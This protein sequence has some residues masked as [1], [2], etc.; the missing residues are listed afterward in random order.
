VNRPD[1]IILVDTVNAAR[2]VIV[3]TEHRI[4]NRFVLSLFILGVIVP[5]GI[6]TIGWF[7]ATASAGESVSSH[8]WTAPSWVVWV[9]WPTW[10]LMFDAEHAANT[11]FMLTIS[12]M[13]NGI[14]YAGL[15]F[16]VWSVTARLKSLARSI[17]SRSLKH[18][19][20]MPD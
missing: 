14:W 13:L 18:H 20:S 2:N 19:D 1:G 12:V 9:I 4:R 5:L 6:M 8:T 17:P 15:S 3:M 7:L 10:I 11:A 16:V